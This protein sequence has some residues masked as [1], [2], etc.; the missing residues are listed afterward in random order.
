MYLERLENKLP[1]VSVIKVKPYNLEEL[2]KGLNYRITER[3][4][5]DTWELERFLAFCFCE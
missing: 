2:G 4:S 1:C 5:K 3:N